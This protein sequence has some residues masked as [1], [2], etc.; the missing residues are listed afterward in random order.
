M[1]TGPIIA[2]QAVELSK[3][4]TKESLQAKIHEIEHELYP[5][6][7]QKLFTD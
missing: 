1:D 7:L 5:S 2:Q 6:I 4:E 3:D